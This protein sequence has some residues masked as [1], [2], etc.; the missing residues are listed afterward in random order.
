MSIQLTSTATETTAP[1]PLDAL[2]P[3]EIATAVG[4]VRASGKLGS[5][6]RFVTVAL[7]EPSKPLVLAYRE[8]DRIERE[9]FAIILDNTDGSTY[10]AVVSISMGAIASWTHIPDVQPSI[11]LDEFFECENTLK[12]DPAFQEA[13]RKRG[14]TDFSLLM[15]DPWSSGYYGEPEDRTFRLA[16]ALTWVRADP[17]DNGYA[18]PVEGLL[19]LVD[20]N[21]M[22][23]IRIEDNGVVPLPT[24]PGNYSTDH[25]KEFRQD[26]RPL[27]ISQPE[28]PSFTVRGHEIRWQKW[29]FRIGF[30]PREGLVLYTIG[31]EDEGRVRPVIYRASLVDMVVPYGDPHPNHNRQNA[32]DVGEYGIGMLA[33]ALELGCDCLGEIRYFDACMTDSRGL[34]TQLKNAVCL[35]E[36]D[37][38]ILWK[39]MDWRTNR[40]EVRR[41]R[42]LV[43][44]F[45]ATVGNY[46]YGFY[47]YFYQDGTLQFEIKMTGILNTGALPDGE[48][49]KYG[50]LVAPGVYAPNH[51]HFFNIRLD[52]MVDG[53]R[54]SV[55]EVHSEAESVGPENPLGNAFYEVSTLLRSEAEAQQLTDPLHAR[56]WKI[57]NPTA[58]N[59]L[60]QPVAYKL[61]PGENVQPFVHPEASVTKRATFI[62][63][64]LW[65]T[66][67]HPGEKYATGDYP[68]QHPGGAGLP[69]WTQANRS[70]EN[71]DVVVWYTIG[72]HHIP[73]PEEWPVMP[74][75]SLG[76]SLKPLGFFDR[77]PALDV[78]PPMSEHC[79]DCVPPG[80]HHVHD[81]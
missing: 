40:T 17:N 57:V 43:V 27:A 51:Q 15:V 50:T 54:N 53:L 72:M 65:V 81:S 26:L 52:M 2:S 8:G 33:N 21:A 77:N 47:W 66:P 20:L 4:I 25:I 71:T 11:M 23:V 42:R 6:A 12:N 19:A 74:V 76:F 45:I 75:S 13:L 62:T 3:E 69:E 55:Y 58:L 67:Y 36:E 5:Q 61:M 35:H 16:R 7:H 64:H 34:L 9:A 14:I 68:N 10:E 79:Q 30:T 31:Y 46:E 80:N 48:T 78:P 39:H 22:K 56:Y 18:H 59:G 37:Y 41:S 24:Q 44:S 32:F 73:R 1:H 38:G 29:R 60:G 70:I 63:K 28:G 49:R